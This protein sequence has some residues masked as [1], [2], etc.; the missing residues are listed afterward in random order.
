[1]LPPPENKTKN[2]CKGIV[3]EG[4]GCETKCNEEKLFLQTPIRLRPILEE[5]NS[6]RTCSGVGFSLAWRFDRVTA[7]H[8]WPGLCGFADNKHFTCQPLKVSSTPGKVPKCI[9][10]D[11]PGGETRQATLSRMKRCSTMVAH[12]NA[13]YAIEPNH[14]ELDKITASGETTVSLNQ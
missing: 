2:E 11:A 6:L 4:V 12:G 9:P 1:M 5:C 3:P 7:P 14:G 8:K 10:T 13:I